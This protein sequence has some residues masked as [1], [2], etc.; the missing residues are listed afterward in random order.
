MTSPI[1]QTRL[2]EL[3]RRWRIRTLVRGAGLAVGLA[4]VTVLGLV[5]LAALGLVPAGARGVLRWI[6]VVALLGPLLGALWMIVGRVPP[7]RRLALQIDEQLP[8]LEQGAA[9]L[10]ELPEAHPYAASIRAAVEGRIGR[11]RDS[12]FAWWRPAEGE[13]R[14]A[15]PVLAALALAGTLL[16]TQGGPGVV[17]GAWGAAASGAGTGAP[18]VAGPMG[19]D[20]ELEEAPIDLPDHLTITLRPP[21]YTG[22]PDREVPFDEGVITLAGSEL[23]L[24]AELPE[25]VDPPELRRI[26]PGSGDGAEGVTGSGADPRGDRGSEVAAWTPFEADGNGGWTARVSLDTGD[27]GL[28]LRHGA[29]WI[30][31][32]Q[33]RPDG[34]PEVE[35]MEPGR[36]MVLA[37]GIGTVQLQA[38]ARDR[39]GIG[40]FELSWMHTRGSGESFDFRD[41]RI[42]WD[43]VEEGADGALEGRLTLDLESIGLGP[44]DVLHLRAVARDRN[45]LTGPGEGVSRTR[46]LRVIREGDEMSVDALIGL[47]V[48]VEQEPVLSQRM[49]LMMTEELLAEAPRMNASDVRSEALR[50]SREQNRLRTR[51]GEEVF[52]RATGAMEEVVLHLG[53]EFDPHGGMAGAAHAHDDDHDDHDH[54]HDRDAEADRTSPPVQG[55]R[56]GVASIFD[57]SA[58]ADTAREPTGVGPGQGAAH[59][60]DH[61]DSRGARLDFGAGENLEPLFMG[62]PGALPVGFGE[63]EELGHDHDGNPILSVNQPLLEI[64]NAMWESE[65]YLSLIDPDRSTPHQQEAL[66]GLQALR[67]NTRVFPRGRVS[68]PPVDVGQARGTGEIDDADPAARMPGERR[69]AA[70]ARIGEMDRV[71]VRIDEGSDRTEPEL[72]AFALSLLEDPVVPTETSSAVVRASQLLQRGELEAASRLLRDTRR[73]WARPA[74]D[75]GVRLVETPLS[76][77][78]GWPG[79]EDRPG[80]ARGVGSPDALSET[81]F[82]FA[83]LRYE[84]GNWDSAPLVPQNLIHSLAQYTELPVA[85]EGVVV[86]LSSDEIF[87]YPVLYLTGHLPVRFSDAEARNL[88]RYVR[89]GG[90]VFMDDHNHDIDGAFH[91]TATAELARIFGPDALEALPSDHELYRSFFHFEDGPPTTSHELSGWGDGLIHPDLYAVLVDGR[92]GVLYSNKDYSSEWS[93]HAVNKRF[94]AVDNTRFGVNLLL[95]ALTR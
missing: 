18:G 53:V 39:Y 71:L 80:A 10:L 11:A 77:M 30:L 91:R 45:D 5:G 23:R 60:H 81:P 8:E 22:L 9:T 52:S 54:E 50:I 7:D 90:F 12:R 26:R 37:T 58:R 14:R 78:T 89:R 20:G 70:D 64:Y 69:E 33:V 21:G 74:R 62:R 3:R 43:A 86:D 40:D 38:R 15:I 1:L 34:P 28:V 95:Y 82:V 79:D 85:P 4:S 87:R 13:G 88:E 51:I 72:H 59:D 32:L 55:S 93:Y 61:G 56:Y 57:P 68:V 48:D 24:V 44:G 19:T 25:G 84:S 47:P 75:R 63:L 65:R 67:E 6:P 42:A 36:D 49:I 76:P 31:P 83:T 46:Q 2:A 92:I 66:D 29:E 41:G 94:L 35:L 73:D 27:R 16:A 17:W